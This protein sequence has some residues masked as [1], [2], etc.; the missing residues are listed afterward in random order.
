MLRACAC[1]LDPTSRPH[2]FQRHLFVLRAKLSETVRTENEWAGKVRA[3]VNRVDALEDSV[4]KKLDAQQMKLDA[5]DAKLEQI[6]GS[7][8][9]LLPQDHD[10]HRHWS[11][12]RERCGSFCCIRWHKQLSSTS[13]QQTRHPARGKGWWKWETRC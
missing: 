4:N 3:V 1:Q 11:V 2:L 12:T 13:R 10:G 5:Q 7:L 6:L 8:Q 9:R